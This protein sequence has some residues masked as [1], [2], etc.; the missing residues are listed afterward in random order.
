MFKK[1]LCAGAIIA[2]IAS[3]LIGNYSASTPSTSKLLP[4]GFAFAIWAIIYFTGLYLAFRVVREKGSAPSR[5]I[6]QIAIGYFLSG[7]WIRFDGHQTVVAFI[8][9]FTLIANVW[10]IRELAKSSMDKRSVNLLATFSG[11]ITIATALVIADATHISTAS[12]TTVAIYLALALVVVF[13]IYLTLNPLLGYIA[14]IAWA[15]FS[16]LFTH[17]TLGTPGVFVAGVGCATAL[18]MVGMRLRAD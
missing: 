6:P 14:T 9:V 1:N 5:G 3:G 13:A 17:T 12:N 7:L 16:L 4:P 8:A 15:C 10:A 11:W 2:G 18:A